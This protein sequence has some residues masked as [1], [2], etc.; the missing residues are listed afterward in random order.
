MSDRVH[1]RVPTT[2]GGEA[3]QAHPLGL[4]AM[5]EEVSSAACGERGGDVRTARP[6]H[7]RLWSS[8]QIGEADEC[9]PWL[10]LRDGSGYGRMIVGS[11]RTSF[12]MQG[13]HRLAYMLTIGPIAHGKCVCHQCDNPACCNPSHMFLATNAENTA[14]RVRKGRSARGEGNGRAKLSAGDVENMRKAHGSGVTKATL[15]RAYAVSDTHVTR[16]IAGTRWSAPR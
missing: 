4:A 3:R 1:A 2:A 15:A 6:V 7:E 8:V 12:R 13:C 11:S 10:G 9:W 16:I 5:D 14:D